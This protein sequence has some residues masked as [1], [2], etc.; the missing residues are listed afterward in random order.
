M[1]RSMLV[2][3]RRS[4]L[5]RAMG[6]MRNCWRLGR[7]LS[8]IV[9]AVLG[10]SLSMYYAPGYFSDAREMDALHAGSARSD[11]QLLHAEQSS[12]ASLLKDELKRWSHGD[13]GQSRQFGIPVS[14]LIRERFA[15]S[16]SLLLTAVVTGWSAALFVAIPLSM[17]RQYRA[18]VAVAAITAILLAIPVGAL[19][20]ICLVANVNGPAL[21]LAL[22]IC[23]RDFKVLHR[24]LKGVWGAPHLLYARAQGL[25]T[26]QILLAHILPSVRREL[27]SMGV[28]SFTLALSALVPVEVV[29]DRPGIGQ[30]AWSAAVNRDLPVLT[31]VTAL[32]ASCVGTASFFV[33]PTQS[34]ESSPCA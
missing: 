14:A 5:S 25:S 26:S 34:V 16:F 31:A 17:R 3:C 28:M 2:N 21:V 23:V 12:V 18:D 30:L 13:L 4:L 32:I 29:F 20:T 33:E 15:S 9:L 11:M 7:V 8:L 27:L 24:T 1:T 22:V 10:T 19:A 6:N